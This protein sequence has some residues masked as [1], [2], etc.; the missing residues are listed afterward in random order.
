MESRRT[1]LKNYILKWKERVLNTEPS[2]RKKAESIV[3]EIYKICEGS[4][5]LSSR[6]PPEIIWVNSPTELVNLKLNI[7]EENYYSWI[8]E[9]FANFSVDGLY[10]NQ[11][12]DE[13]RTQ[14]RKQKDNIVRDLALGETYSSYP[15]FRFKE[16]LE[17]FLNSKELI[18][19]LVYISRLFSSYKK[20]SVIYAKQ[21]SFKMIEHSCHFLDLFFCWD[22]LNTFYNIAQ[23]PDSKILF[24]SEYKWWNQIFLELIDSTFMWF[25]H[26]DVA[27]L[28]ERP[29]KIYVDKKGNIH[30]EDKPAIIF[31]DGTSLWAFQGVSI[32]EDLF[33][34]D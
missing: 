13:L 17:D 34:E 16:F 25:I 12:I 21:A 10:G 5:L 1:H 23:I 18:N 28:C 27:I 19:K 9:R 20:L 30:R 14:F 8:C 7:R 6:N 4:P 31:R 22:Y 15:I 2:D 26:K 29:A 32:S 33:K 11:K 24:D 3:K